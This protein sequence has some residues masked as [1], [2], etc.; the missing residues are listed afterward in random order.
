MIKI[1]GRILSEYHINCTPM[2]LYHKC[3]WWEIL[4]LLYFSYE[5]KVLEDLAFKEER[6]LAELEEKLRSGKIKTFYKPNMTARQKE[7]VAKYTKR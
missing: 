4:G 2:E 7:L 1:A 3:E 5:K 6:E